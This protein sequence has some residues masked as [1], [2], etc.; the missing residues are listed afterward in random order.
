MKRTSLIAIMLVVMIGLLG[1]CAQEPV[2]DEA[3][4]AVESTEQ[5]SEQSDDPTSAEEDSNK[6]AILTTEELQGMLGDENVILVD[7]R[8]TYAFNGW[9]M[10]GEAEGG[11]IEGALLFSASWLD[12]LESDED[13]QSELDRYG[14][15]AG[16]TVVTYGYGTEAAERVAAKLNELG[17]ESVYVYGDGLEGWMASADAQLEKMANYEMLVHPKWVQEELEAGEIS[18][19]E[20]SWG[21]GDKYLEAHIPGAVHINTD[22]FEEGPVWNFKS[23]DQIEAS[24]LAYGITK[25]S[26]V[27]L[28]GEDTTAAARIALILKYAG[29]EDVRLLDGGFQMWKDAGYE[30][31]QGGVEAVAV[32]SFGVEVPQNPQY[33]M[34]MEDAKNLLASENGRLVSIR[35][36]SEYIGETSGY[37]YIEAA[38]RIEGD[39]YGFSGSDPWHMEEYRTPD[40]TMVNYEYMADRWLA[41]GISPDTVNAFYCGTGWR[42]SEAW[43]YALAMNWENVSVYDGGWKEWSETEGNPTATGEPESK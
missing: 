29:V 6:E 40:N 4:T 1:G 31:A 25:D 23:D 22:D 33:V 24:L 30:I 15:S 21:P 10:N 16:K 28:Y 27:V 42:A 12:K 8:S 20:V 37:D 26:A 34:S 38:G 2:N 14:I 9:A 43:F 11:H 13:V 32:E 35:S 36:W 39:V 18:L 41:Q 7:T 17:Y 19:F 3:T 5:D